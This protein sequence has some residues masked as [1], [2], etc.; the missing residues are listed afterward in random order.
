MSTDYQEQGYTLLES[1]FD[2]KE[3]QQIKKEVAHALTTIN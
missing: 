2:K 1:F 3:L